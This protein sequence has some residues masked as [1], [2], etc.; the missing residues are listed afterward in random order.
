MDV[1]HVTM[2]THRVISNAYY[3]TALTQGV[4]VDTYL[5]T[6]HNI[7]V[8]KHGIFAGTWQI[9]HDPQGGQVF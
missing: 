3:V 2:Q 7:C 5:E 1:Y 4:T 6:M 9:L 8:S